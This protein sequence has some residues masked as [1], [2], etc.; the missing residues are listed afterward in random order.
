MSYLVTA[1][2]M[3]LGYCCYYY[4]YRPLP[5]TGLVAGAEV[6]VSVVVVV[7]A[8]AVVTVQLQW[9]MKWESEGYWKWRY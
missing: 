6:E 3:E 2:A 4:C 9:V 8:V 5:R 7:D 1:L